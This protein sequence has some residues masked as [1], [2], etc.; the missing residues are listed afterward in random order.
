M[1]APVG[2]SGP[3]MTPNKS[4]MVQSGL[5]IKRIKPW[6]NSDK[7]WDGMEVDIP[8]A[9]P[10]EPLANKLGKAAGKTVGSCSSPS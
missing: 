10:L 7:L 4:L 3:L 8:T 6:I 2:K 1:L 5:S 9:I